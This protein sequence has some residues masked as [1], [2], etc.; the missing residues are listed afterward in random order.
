MKPVKHTKTQEESLGTRSLSEG[1]RVQV[2]FYENNKVSWKFGEITRKYGLLH[3][4]VLLDNGYSLKRH[5][6]QLRSTRVPKK[7][8][9]FTVDQARPHEKEA[10][11]ESGSDEYQPL[12]VTTQANPPGNVRIQ[13]EP[14][15]R[16]ESQ[17]EAPAAEEGRYSRRQRCAPR[18]LRD[19]VTDV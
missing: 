8:V 10:Q 19:Y 6:D 2:K 16:M 1:E 14:P 13:P 5:I 7:V 4:Q 15:T 3:Y 9:R 17:P 11:I 12:I 18:Y